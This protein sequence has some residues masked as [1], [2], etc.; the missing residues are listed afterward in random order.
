MWNRDKIMMG[1]LDAAL[2]EKGIEQA[3]ELATHLQSI[4]FSA[5]YSS[6]SLRAVRTA[7]IVGRI[8]SLRIKK[9]AKL[10][11]RDFAQFE[12]MSVLAYKE[13]NKKS[14]LVRDA[15]PESKRWNFTLA[16]C[17][18]SDASLVKRVISALRRIS[19]GHLGKKVLVSTH[20][21][22]IRMLLMKLGHAPYGSL[23]GGSFKN[24]GYIV[25]ESD[26]IELCVKEIH[27]LKIR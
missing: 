14:L 24:C 27:G 20:G 9:S 4:E 13:Q 21:G 8:D 3:N 10:R 17:V 12:G 23:P 16:G 1:H 2:T 25:V 11:E 5:V 6:D 22:P 15:L 26:G 19:V 18:E 7:S